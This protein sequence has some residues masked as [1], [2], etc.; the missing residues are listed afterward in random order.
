[1]IL[2]V[3]SFHI[4]SSYMIHFIY[5][6]IIDSF[7]TGT[8]EPTNDQQSVYDSFHLSFRSEILF[9]LFLPA[10]LQQFDEGQ[11]GPLFCYEDNS[12][13]STTLSRI[14]YGKNLFGNQSSTFRLTAHTRDTALYPA[15]NFT[16]SLRPWR[17][18][19]IA[20]SR[21]Q[22]PLKSRIFQASLRNCYNCVRNCKDH[23]FT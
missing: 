4:R 3:T 9:L 2:A 12:E 8:L 5:H 19:V 13:R 14:F 17:R 18:T 23:S 21:V 10:A 16:N 22:T 15:R 6:F 20:R 11:S 7:L 1:M